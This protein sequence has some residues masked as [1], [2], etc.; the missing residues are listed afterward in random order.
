[1]SRWNDTDIPLAYLISFR[2]Y[3]TWLHGD[4]R[5]STD[6]FHHHYKSPHLPPNVAWKTHN[7]RVLKCPPVKLNAARRASTE[8]ALRETCAKRGW[9]LRA[10]N[11]RTN[12]VHAVV[13][14]GEV[15][16]KLAL[17]AFKAN[18]TRQMR[19]DHCWPHPHSPWAER[20]SKRNLW[21][22]RAV[23]RAIDYVLNGQGDD[24]P[25]FD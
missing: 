12:H 9:L 25:D 23:E 8:N 11:V 7:Q 6:R 17:N 19:E 2:C 15:K 1:M 14:I 18:A 22:E 21:N 3:G 20:G 4:E 10:I 5:G 24:L 16:P 13:S